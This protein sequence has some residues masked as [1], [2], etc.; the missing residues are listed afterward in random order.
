MPNK[1]P[2]Q[3][4]D[5][6]LRLNRAS[7]REWL[8]AL[9]ALSGWDGVECRLGTGGGTAGAL[10]ALT[11]GLGRVVCIHASQAMEIT[12]RSAPGPVLLLPR[13]A[14]SHGVKVLPVCA[15]HS[16]WENVLEPVGDGSLA[17]RLGFR[18]IKGFSEEDGLWLASARGSGYRSIEAIWRR[19]G[20]S[21]PALSKLA[22]AD[23]F[24]GH[25]DGLHRALQ[26]CR[27]V[28]A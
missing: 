20:L 28:R 18:Q 19:A 9:R 14:R 24:A 1:A 2:D 3:E 17:V 4:L 11:S 26:R 12:G 25:S 23:A 13:D 10:S 7:P 21:R 6:Y 8:V 5:A 27:L 15:E 16:Y 22:G